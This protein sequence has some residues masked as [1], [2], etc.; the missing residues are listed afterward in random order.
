[1][2]MR[3]GMLATDAFGKAGGQCIQ[4]RGN[5]RVMRNITIPTQRQASTQN[6][7]R[8]INSA[9]FNSWQF[10]S[11]LVRDEWAF[12][13]QNLPRL[14]GW[15]DSKTLS[16]REAYTSLNSIWGPYAGTD[17]DP[18]II[19]FSVPTIEVASLAV[20]VENE[21]FV[22]SAIASGNTE[23]VQMKVLKLPSLAV[24]PNVSKLKT[25]ARTDAFGEADTNFT[26]L[27][28]AVPSLRV[29]TIL[30]ISIRAVSSSGI[31]SPWV[32][33]QIIANA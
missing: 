16:G 23:F 22:V 9:L 1:M 17:L 4:R 24:N 19:D 6:P 30:S 10:L 5:I 28:N 31:A 27:K 3:F 26:L 7:Q 15:G 13:G 12:V 11:K 21:E 14:N 32:Q 18:S 33:K 2:K 29:G 8:F 20:S 25:F